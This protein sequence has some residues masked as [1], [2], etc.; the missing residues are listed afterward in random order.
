ML[1]EN[2]NIDSFIEDLDPNIWK[3]VCMLTEPKSSSAK[4]GI[5]T[6]NPVRKIRRFYAICVLFF[7][8][9]ASLCTHYLLMQWTHV[10]DHPDYRS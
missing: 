1:I 6:T 2:M 10:V 5:D 3:G 7:A 8:T 4:K 9:N